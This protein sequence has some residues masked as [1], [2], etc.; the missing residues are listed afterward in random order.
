MKINTNKGFSLAEL[1]VSA[2]LLGGLALV[3]MTL[4]DQF[5][6]TKKRGENLVKIVDLSNA[7]NRFVY[8]SQGCNEFIGKVISNTPEDFTINSWNYLG[9][10]R[11]AATDSIEGIRVLSMQARQSLDA[12]LP[13]IRSGT[14]DLI[15]TSLQLEIVL[16]NEGREIKNFYH[17]PVLSRPS[18]RIESCD[19]MQTI[20]DICNTLLGN[21]NPTTQRCELENTCLLRGTYK[22]LSCY[23]SNGSNQPCSEDY[24]LDENNI[25]TSDLTCPA[26]STAAQT[27]IHAWN[28]TVSCGKKCTITV[29][30]TATWFTCLECP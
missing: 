24:G 13:R 23:S 16:E 6:T 19:V 10:S 4:G 5:N 26:G 27:G 8:S 22:T 18:G 25:F 14:R 30:N 20:A 3:V 17:L 2:G 21:F 7:L 9:A 11:L 15:K 28:H 12:S 1:M 29:S